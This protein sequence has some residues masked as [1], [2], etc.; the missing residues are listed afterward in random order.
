MAIGLLDAGIHQVLR[1][2]F[3][4]TITNTGIHQR[5]SVYYN[6]NLKSLFSGQVLKTNA[7]FVLKQT[8]PAYI[9]C[10]HF[11]VLRGS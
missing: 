4:C 11:K 10:C 2:Y 1:A 3:T 8:A 5:T 7:D 6:R 9:V